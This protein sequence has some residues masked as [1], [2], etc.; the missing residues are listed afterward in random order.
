MVLPEPV[1][2]RVLLSENEVAAR[3]REV[4][5]WSRAGKAI[6]RTWT[7]RDFSEALALINKV[8]ALSEAMNH[9]PDIANSWA[10]V[11][12]TLTP[13]DQGGLTSLASDLAN[14]INGL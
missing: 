8:G 5:G 9:H 3:L 10:T 14:K 13:H 12:L 6:E 2:R 1:A 11:R 7:F 4:T